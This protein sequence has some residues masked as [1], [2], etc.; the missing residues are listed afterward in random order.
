MR[1]R[2]IST[3]SYSLFFLI[4]LALFYTQ[5]VQYPFYSKL[6]KNNSIRIIPING[7]RGSLYDRNGVILVSSRLAFDV[8]VI[9]HEI[10]ER[11]RLVTLLAGVLDMPERKIE[12]AVEIA[13]ARPFSAVVIASDVEKSKAIALEEASFDLDGILIETRSLRDYK[14]KRD[15]AH[16]FGHLGEIS[17]DELESL[18]D[19]GYRSRDLVGRSGLEKYYNAELTGVS[20]GK[21]IEV[22]SRGR[23]TRILGVREPKDGKDLSLTIDIRMQK[24]A[25]E[26]LGDRTGAIVVMNPTTGEILAFASHPSFDPNIFVRTDSGN[27]RRRLILDKHGKPLLNR[28]ISGLYPPGSVF[29]IVT[30]AQGLDTGKISRSTIFQC[31]GSY[32]LGGARFG[33]WKEDG[34]GP[35][36]IIRALMN[37]C[38]VFFYNTGR[39]DGAD[40]LERMG[41]LFGFG[42]R[43][44]IDLPDE[45][46]GTLPGRGWKMRVKGEGWYEGDTVNYSIGQG[47]LTVTPLQVVEML[48]AI[49]NGGYLVRPYIVKEAG[50]VPIA[51]ANPVP[52]GLKE[53]TISTIREGLLKVVSSEEGTGKRAK[54]E[55]VRVAGKTGSAQNPNGKTHAWITVFAP[56]EEPS[57]ALVVLVEHGGHGGLEPGEIARTILQ[58]AKD[59]EYI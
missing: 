57:I 9:Y 16:I 8:S 7:P 41:G 45:A 38:D 3:I 2:V 22:D 21:Q 54:I 31:N 14:Y 58:K 15:G 19:Y 5:V 43:S 23:V 37:S 51:R 24:T 53:S 12:N 13:S 59:L 52:L 32:K 29:K 10:R 42:R 39:L 46:R 27:E 26:A 56:Y 25:D 20:G 50:G 34:H 4:A 11:D 48:S 28:A 35:Q 6:A 55:G 33:C 44:G 30:A 47:Y 49:A 40:G 17:Q 36:D 18:A 1:D